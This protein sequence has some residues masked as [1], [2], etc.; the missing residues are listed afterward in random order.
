MFRLSYLQVSTS[1]CWPGKQEYCSPYGGN[2]PKTTKSQ[3]SRGRPP[4]RVVKSDAAASALAQVM[5]IA[6]KLLD[7]SISVTK[8]SSNND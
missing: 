1:K 8:P 2:P 6:A 5:L 4:T 7:M 3:N